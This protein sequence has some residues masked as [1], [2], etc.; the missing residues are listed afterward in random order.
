MQHEKEKGLR[1]AIVGILVLFAACE[2]IEIRHAKTLRGDETLYIQAAY[3]MME[4]GDWLTPRFESGALRFMKP[5]LPYW[6]VG[7]PMKVFGLSL[8]AARLPSVLLAL[9]TL[10]FVYGLARALLRDRAAAL[11]AVAAYISTETVYSNA[12]QARTDTLLTFFVAGAMYFFAR[13]IF[14]PGSAGMPQLSREDARS[15]SD[16]KNALCAYGLTAGAILTKGLAGVAFILLPVAAFLA[17][18]WKGTGRAR[19]R[20]VASP[21][22]WALLLLITIPWYAVMLTRHGQVFSKMFLTDQVAQNLGGK[23]S[24]VMSVLQNFVEYPCLFFKDCLPW[25]VPVVLS[26]VMNDPASAGKGPLRSM[27]RERRAQWLF[28]VTWFATTYLIFLFGNVNRGR[29]LLPVLPAFTA[30]AGF[31]VARAGP[32]EQRPRGFTW[33]LYV[34]ALGA[35][36]VGLACIGHF[37]VWPNLGAIPA[38]VVLVVGAVAMFWL[39]RARRL[40]YAAFCGGAMMIVAL[41]SVSAFFVAPAPME[42][43]A[44]LTSE[45][46]AAIGPETRIATVGLSKHVRTVILLSCGR[47]PAEWPA[48]GLP[49]DKTP[50]EQARF[51]R[52]FLA[53][54][55][56]KLVFADGDVFGSL[57]SEVREKWRIAASKTGYAEPDFDFWNW[58]RRRPTTLYSLI[59]GKLVTLCLLRPVT[60]GGGQ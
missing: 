4:S 27:F 7:A 9:A 39:T 13:L 19:L 31:V 20:A 51:L 11:F 57:P 12:H 30:L 21:S 49:K 56:D 17:I 46:R 28:L 37:F 14:E 33:G 45:N 52:D 10:P 24:L 42:T 47:R 35:W 34:A 48:E 43:A 18:A 22:G 59:Q 23:R 38:G 5:I 32:A 8:V 53:E 29:Y 41:M 1:W 16:F 15:S 2:M 40:Q 3:T 54:P 44:V 60:S 6:V 36:I 55:G 25:S 50:L 26:L 58:L